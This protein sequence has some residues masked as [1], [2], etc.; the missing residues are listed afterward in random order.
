MELREKN[1]QCRRLREEADSSLTITHGLK[2]GL[3]R[4]GTTAIMNKVI[5]KKCQLIR[6]V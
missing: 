4:A 3:G 2:G 6:Q 1:E 5:A